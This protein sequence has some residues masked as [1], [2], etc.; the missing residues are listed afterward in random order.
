MISKWYE[1]KPIAIKLRGSGKSIRTIESN[2]K[3]PRSTLSGWFKYI[4][5]SEKQLASLEQNRLN[6]LNKAR[7]KA[8]TWHNDQKKQGIIEAEK[9]SLLTLTN[10]DVGNKFIREL[11]L[12]M[13]Y[14]GEGFKGKNGIG[15]GNSDVLILKFFIQI[16]TKDFGISK[17][18]I[19]LYLHLRDD[20]NPI[21]LKNY[22]SRELNIP[23]K[24]FGKASIDKRTTG[25]PTY[26]S[27]HGVCVLHCGNIAIQRKLLF[28]SKKFC[29]KIIS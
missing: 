17:D 20:Q 24:N 12:A 19:K 23:M 14:L 21:L 29:E 11:A 4:K 15:I 25:N 18:K 13:L 26:S 8:V 22:W 28:I 2:L 7:H 3:I 10:L 5:L 9:Q 16:I 27:Y 6:N 1:L